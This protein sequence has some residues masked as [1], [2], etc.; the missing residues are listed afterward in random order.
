MLSGILPT[1]LDC[2]QEFL[3]EGSGRRR[4]LSFIPISYNINK[5]WLV[6]ILMKNGKL[7]PFLGPKWDENCNINYCNLLILRA[8]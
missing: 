8:L 3:L 4:A 2:H 5:L 6:K 7:P 1:L